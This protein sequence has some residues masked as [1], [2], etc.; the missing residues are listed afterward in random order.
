M[1]ENMITRPPSVSAQSF[2]LPEA[3]KS[4]KCDHFEWSF[5]TK[6]KGGKEAEILALKHESRILEQWSDPVSRS[7]KSQFS[8]GQA[9]QSLTC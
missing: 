7:N 2:A 4:Q 8:V 9:A 5:T 6:T 3:R 1:P